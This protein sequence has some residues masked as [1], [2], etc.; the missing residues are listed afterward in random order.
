MPVPPC[1]RD[2][3]DNTVQMTLEIDDK[4]RRCALLKITADSI[5]VMIMNSVQSLHANEEILEFMSKVTTTTTT[6]V[7][8]ITIMIIIIIIIIIVVVVAVVVIK[9][10][11]LSTI[12]VII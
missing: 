5:K 4:A 12:K 6:I 9:T 7:I 11:T 3:G 2:S 8:V 10:T 1:I